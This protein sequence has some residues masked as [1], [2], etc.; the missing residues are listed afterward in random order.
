MRAIIIIIAFAIP[1]LHFT[2]PAS[3]E[4]VTLYAGTPVSLSLNQVVN[5]EHVE[6]GHTV[7]FLVRNNVMLN[8][9][10]LVATGTIAEGWVQSVTKR[11]TGR[12]NRRCSEVTITVESVQAVDGQRIYLRSIPL[13]IKGD[14]NRNQPAEIKLG[15]VASA[16]VLNNIKINA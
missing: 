7:E 16:R 11:C 1:H 5:S 10:V 8:G 4:M 9:K 15:T 13:T 3:N 14:C 6:V 2:N 12:C